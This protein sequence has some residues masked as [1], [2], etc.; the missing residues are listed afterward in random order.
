MIMKKETIVYMLHIKESIGK[1]KGYTTGF[2]QQDFLNNT[3]VQDAVTRNFQII[4]EAVKKVPI[5]FQQKYS[6]IE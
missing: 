2:T 5:E 3:M 6:Q 4:G 1:I